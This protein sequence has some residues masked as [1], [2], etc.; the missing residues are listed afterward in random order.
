MAAVDRVFVELLEQEPSW[1]VLV[2]W[3]WSGELQVVFHIPRDGLQSLSDH[4][5]QQIREYLNLP[6]NSSIIIANQEEVEEMEQAATPRGKRTRPD[7]ACR[8]PE[9]KRAHSPP[10]IGPGQLA[11]LSVLCTKEGNEC[12]PASESSAGDMSVCTVYLQIRIAR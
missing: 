1:K 3:A 2:S 10:D 8:T 12:W 9:K 5:R 4:I 7:L 6:E 11:V